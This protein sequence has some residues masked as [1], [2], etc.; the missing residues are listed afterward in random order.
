MGLLKDWEFY[1]SLF[2][3]VFMNVVLFTT[4]GSL[5]GNAIARRLYSEKMLLKVIYVDPG[6]GRGGQLSSLYSYYR[7]YGF[8]QTVRKIVDVAQLKLF[9]RDLLKLNIPEPYFLNVTR[10]SQEKLFRTLSDLHP[11]LCISASYRCIF[12]MRIIRVPRYFLNVHPSLLPQYRGSNP[13]YWVLRNHEL[14]TGVTYH[15]LTKEVDAG[16]ILMQSQL[17]ITPSDDEFSLKIKLSQLAQSML[18]EA[19]KIVLT[20]Y[21]GTQQ[22][23]SISYAPDHD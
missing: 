6:Y 18:Q 4:R 5:L 8:S 12:P 21:S 9:R 7:R 16:N 11:V 22:Q 10:Y 3:L 15:F 19:I 2:L 20:G 1:H 23:G 14:Y 17:P 13:I